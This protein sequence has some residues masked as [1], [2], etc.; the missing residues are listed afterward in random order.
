MDRKQSR[1]LV[2]QKEGSSMVI[3]GEQISC[4]R[5][6]AACLRISMI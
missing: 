3:D 1:R 5:D 6:L 2:L 4:L